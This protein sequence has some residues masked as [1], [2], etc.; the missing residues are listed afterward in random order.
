MC[1]P[2]VPRLWSVASCVCGEVAAGLACPSLSSANTTDNIHWATS[3]LG[4]PTV[5]RGRLP[6]ADFSSS[7]LLPTPPAGPCICPAHS[8][9]LGTETLQARVGI[10]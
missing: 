4:L 7:C 10:F 3:S 9:I 8:S 1:W 2:T 5:L 6:K